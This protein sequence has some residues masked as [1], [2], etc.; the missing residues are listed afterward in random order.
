MFCF[1]KVLGEGAQL[2]HSQ[3]KWPNKSYAPRLSYQE[4]LGNQK[5]PGK[6]VGLRSS[7]HLPPGTV[8]G[9][10]LVC[11]PMAEPMDD[12][13]IGGEK[14]SPLQGHNGVGLSRPSE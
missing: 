5:L 9:V 6:V 8:F 3:N 10:Q 2:R 14:C 11:K 13:C 7:V 12:A 4:L 1:P